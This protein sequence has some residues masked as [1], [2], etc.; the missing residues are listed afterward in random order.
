MDFNKIQEI[1]NAD[2]SRRMSSKKFQS[3]SKKIGK[4]EVFCDNLTT[5]D[6]IDIR[7]RMNSGLICEAER[8]LIGKTTFSTDAFR[9]IISEVISFIKSL[10]KG[11]KEQSKV[12][13]NDMLIIYQLDKKRFF[14]IY[15]WIIISLE[16]FLDFY[17]ISL[18]Y[19]KR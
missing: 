15:D 16:I 17:R 11:L 18:G 3:A 6:V 4:L 9:I 13:R 2:I 12:T 10:L 7:S 19:Q 5:G 1:C 8:R 14:N